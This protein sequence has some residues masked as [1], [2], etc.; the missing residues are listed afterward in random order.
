VIWI[1]RSVWLAAAVTALTCGLAGV[2][3]GE[4]IA[5][6]MSQTMGPAMFATVGFVGIGY[7][8]AG[9]LILRRRPRHAVGWLL[10]VAG[11]VLGAEF[12][13][14]AV[15]AQLAFDGD[16]LGGWVLAVTAAGFW[17]TVMLAGPVVALLFPDGRLPSPRWRRPVLA[18][19]VLFAAAIVLLLLRPGPVSV[20]LE[21]YTPINPIGA[22]WLPGIAFEIA[23]VTGSV[24]IPVT[25][26]A[27][28]SSVAVRFRRAIGEERQQLKWFTAAA[29]LWGIFVVLTLAL[30]LPE[31]FSIAVFA[32]L[33]LLPLSILIAISRYR[34]YEID[35]LVSRALVYVPL[36]GIVAGLYAASVA[37]FQRVFVGLTGNTSDA[38]AIISA[39]LLAAVFTPIRKW[40][41]AIVDRRFKPAP[42]AAG[43]APTQPPAWESPAFDAAVER[44]VRRVLADGALTGAPPPRPTDKVRRRSKPDT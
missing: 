28:V 6:F 32:C 19:V 33:L 35:S 4:V 29:L 17:P 36:V 15:G 40:L 13:S 9:M 39:L 20:E 1:A 31:E 23:D 38:A 3:F 21:E 2:L 27:A 5:R 16:A 42:A 24:A 37:L 12:A 44:V 7:A 10:L 22:S 18:V 30:A 25:L 8:S 34:L 41:E 43:A 26:L 11:F 14:L